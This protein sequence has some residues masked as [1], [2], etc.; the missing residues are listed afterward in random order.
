MTGRR[1]MVMAG[2][3]AVVILAA[4][5]VQMATTRPP[6]PATE[7]V[8]VGPIESWAVYDGSLE[9]REVRYVMSQLGG[10][11]TIVEL[12]A[13][14]S[15]ARAGDVLVR[16]DASQWE[17][18]V[19]RL[20]RDEALAREALSSLANAKIPLELADLDG[21][22]EDVRR[23]AA[24]EERALSDL[25]ELYGDKLIPAQEVGQQESRLA[26]AKV[27]LEAVTKK[28]ELT[29]Q[30]LHPSALGQAGATLASARQELDFARRQ[31][32]NCVV[33]AA[34]DGIVGLKPIA[35]G[36]EY[37][38]AR[39]GD[40]VFKN[41]PFMTLSDATQ[42]VLRCEAPEA[43]RARLHMGDPAYISP[44]AYPD[45]EVPGHIAAIASFAATSPGRPDGQKY[46]VVTIALD[47]ADPLLCGGM[48]ARARVRGSANPGAVR[49]PRAAVWWD[50]GRARCRV[51]TP[52]Q[53]IE[54]TIRIGVADDTHF[55][56]LDGVKAGDRVI[57]P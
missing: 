7:A 47:S 49:I 17:R 40:A 46:F 28:R 56:V 11:A 32:S 8:S 21:Q 27:A 1:K 23:Q 14:G 12:A 22:V 3:V 19:L 31:L 37:R 35:V 54:T 4:A 48:S 39:I 50:G 13:D 9:P 26:A 29:R 57:I 55:E 10:P 53:T 41:Q 24:A 43:E 36:G 38:S 6:P 52:R 45:T 34:A 51:W 5:A 16:F 15:R 20:E 30:Y 42:L 18:D 33:L 2:G 25:R 44:A